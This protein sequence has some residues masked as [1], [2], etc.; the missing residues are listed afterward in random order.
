MVN[1]PTKNRMNGEDSMRP[2]KKASFSATRNPLS[3]PIALSSGPS[4]G[5]VS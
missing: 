5:D 1:W 2:P 4:L 3:G